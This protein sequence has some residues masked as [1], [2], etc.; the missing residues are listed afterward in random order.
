MFTYI[1]KQIKYTL[2]NH[3]F[4][5]KIILIFIWLEKKDVYQNVS[6]GVNYYVLFSWTFSIF[7]NAKMY[8]F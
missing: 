4:V 2:Y 1:I 8:Y 5:L 7:Y 6:L 3:S